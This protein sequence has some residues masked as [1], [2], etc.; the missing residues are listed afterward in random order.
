MNFFLSSLLIPTFKRGEWK[1]RNFLEQEYAHLHPSSPPSHL[2]HPFC[3]SPSVPL[4]GQ[5]CRIATTLICWAYWIRSN[6]YFNCSFRKEYRSYYSVFFIIFLCRENQIWKLVLGKVSAFCEKG[7]TSIVHTHRKK[8]RFEQLFT[9]TCEYKDT[10]IS[11]IAN[12]NHC[13][14]RNR[15]RQPI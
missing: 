1:I 2:P 3:F 15:N 9:T 6:V 12:Q 4:A 11:S 5:L 8:N 7:I 14:L 10:V 13:L